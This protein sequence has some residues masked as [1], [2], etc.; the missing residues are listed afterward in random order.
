[1][2]YMYFC[3]G[4][5]KISAA[6]KSSLNSRV[7]WNIRFVLLPSTIAGGNW[8]PPLHNSVLCV[9]WHTHTLLCHSALSQTVLSESGC[10]LLQ[11]LTIHGPFCQCLWPGDGQKNP[12]NTWRV[13]TLLQ[14]FW[15]KIREEC[16]N[17]PPSKVLLVKV[18]LFLEDQVCH[19][20]NKTKT[21]AKNKKQVY[22]GYVFRENVSYTVPTRACFA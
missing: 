15:L 11:D 1:M 17:F 4:F 16:R 12:S 10:W 2:V 22:L 8:F 19:S 21:K 14:P 6:E 5:L 18:N 9:T 7:S 13:P 20:L 3:H